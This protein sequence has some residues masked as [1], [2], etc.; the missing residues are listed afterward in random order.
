MLSKGECYKCREKF[1][2][3]HKCPAY[4]QL[5]VLEELLEVLQIIDTMDSGTEHV[6]KL[7]V[8]AVSGTTSKQS[9]RLQGQV[10]KY[11]TLILI[12]PGAPATSSARLEL[13]DYN[14]LL[15]PCSI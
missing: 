14:M 5:H 1:A 10:S 2:P 9:M 6:L 15:Q 3:G 7:S 13:I 4:V 12:D 8:Q 11:T